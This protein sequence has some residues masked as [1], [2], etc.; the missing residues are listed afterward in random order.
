MDHIPAV[1]SENTTRT[2]TFMI[3]PVNKLTKSNLIY[4][5]WSFIGEFGGWVGLFIGLSVPDLFDYGWDAAENLRGF[6]G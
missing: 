6:L 5:F 1:P 2:F 3:N 4:D